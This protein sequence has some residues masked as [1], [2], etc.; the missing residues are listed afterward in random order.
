MALDLEMAKNLNLLADN[1][2]HFEILELPYSSYF[3]QNFEIP[4]VNMGMA[5]QPTPLVD[6]PQPGDKVDFQDLNMTFIVDEKL[7]SYKEIWKWIMHLGYPRNTK[8]YKNLVTNNSPYVR[9]SDIIL[10][11]LTNK[12]NVQEQIHFMDCFPY[13]LSGIQLSNENPEITHPTAT[14]TFNYT[15]YYFKGDETFGA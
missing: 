9:K 7:E 6:I 13:A 11:T 8:E 3:T 4:G 15:A 10:S 14:A 5:I 2:F 12:F 1:A